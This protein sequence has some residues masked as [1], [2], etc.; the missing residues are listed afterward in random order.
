MRRNQKPLAALLALALAFCCFALSGCAEDGAAERTSGQDAAT[1]AS[2]QAA[3]EEAGSPD[4][5]AGLPP[6]G[7]NPG[8]APE[9]LPEWSGSPSVEVE[10]GVP[11]FSEEEI[12]R[13]KAGAFEE[14]G[15]LDSL[16][17]CTVAFA[18]VGQETM[19]AGERED[20]SEVKPTGWRN[21][22]YDF[23]DGELLYNRCH[24]L[25]RQ[26]TAEDANERNLVTGTRYMN[27]QG[28]L[29]Y[30]N[31]VAEYV[32]K[33]GN[34]VLMRVTPVFSG[35][36]LLARGVRMEARSVEDEGAGVA[37]DVYCY[38]VQPDVSIDYATGDNAL[39]EGSE[40]EALGAGVVKD[41]V[42]NLNSDKFHEPECPAVAKMAA[43]NRK[44]VAATRESLLAQGYEP[45][46]DC[47]P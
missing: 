8:I 21:S 15:A 23:V 40:A 46:G 26:L 3:Q 43:H 20:I 27:T 36:D 11:A 31:E 5:Q 25:G 45:C 35:E 22:S 16:G 33:T 2:Q 30:E 47:N 41:Y 7:Q 9:A 4:G 44:D 42:L 1:G 13:A 39:A 29:P 10:D 34:H 38:N 14:Y 18:C 19:P 17:R 6:S 32:R 12:A 28:M 37:F 24:L